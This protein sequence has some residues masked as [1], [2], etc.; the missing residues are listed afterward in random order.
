MEDLGGPTPWVNLPSCRDVT[1]ASR[2]AHRR[3]RARPAGGRGRRRAAPASAPPGA[4][5]YGRV[6]RRGGLRRP[7]PPLTPSSWRRASTCACSSRRARR[8]CASTSDAP[9]AGRRGRG[10][11]RG[12][13]GPRARPGDDA[14]S[15]GLPTGVLP[16]LGA[17]A[18][19][20]GARRAR[21]GGRRLPPGLPSRRAARGRRRA[22]WARSATARWRWSSRA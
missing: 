17:R 18:P 9:G 15:V 5:G 19:R 4:G 13:D 3:R 1:A 14:R 22:R 16:H 7:R 10:R 21:R 2:P 6:R 20:G 11:V 12:D 8:H